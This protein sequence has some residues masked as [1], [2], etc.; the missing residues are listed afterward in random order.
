[1]PLEVKAHVIL[2]ENLPPLEIALLEQYCFK[3]VRDQHQPIDQF[4]LAFK[5]TGYEL[6]GALTKLSVIDKEDPDLE[7]DL[8]VPAHYVFFISDTGEVKLPFGL[9][10]G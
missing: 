3:L 6:G 1:M 9:V 5:C 4:L 10:P 7:Y 8:W 2:H